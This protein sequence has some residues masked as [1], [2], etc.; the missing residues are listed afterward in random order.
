MQL[1][2][3]NLLAWIWSTQSKMPKV[4][5]EVNKS[6]SHGLSTVKH[7]KWIIS[8]NFPRE[9]QGRYYYI[10]Y[11]LQKKT[12][13]TEMEILAYHPI[14]AGESQFMQFYLSAYFVILKLR[15]SKKVTEGSQEK[16][17]TQLPAELGGWHPHCV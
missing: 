8:H 5:P 3:Q 1:Y 12:G 10:I 11:I 17:A 4:H 6:L 2:S 9:L 16:K 15:H 13:L 7:F 14:S